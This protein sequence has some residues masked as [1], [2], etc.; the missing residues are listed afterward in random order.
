MVMLK[1]QTQHKRRNR[2][3]V[4]GTLPGNR[5]LA[6]TAGVDE[7]DLPDKTIV[8]SMGTETIKNETGTEVRAVGTPEGE[9][10]R[11]ASIDVTEDVIRM[12]SVGQLRS[13]VI[14]RLRTSGLG[15]VEMC[16]CMECRPSVLL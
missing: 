16:S 7:G 8:V 1:V 14:V 6:H 5:T 11:D 3:V 13:R 9:G 15:C 10:G 12:H 2:A 4:Y